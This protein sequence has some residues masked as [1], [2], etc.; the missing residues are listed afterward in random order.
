MATSA[1]A[2]YYLGLTLLDLG[3]TD[4]AIKELEGVVRSGEK[5]A[6]VYLSLGASYLDAGRFDEGLQALTRRR[7]LIRRGPTSRSSSPA[8]IA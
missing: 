2:H 8:R 7:R 3:Q 4:E 1:Q 6:D 5:R